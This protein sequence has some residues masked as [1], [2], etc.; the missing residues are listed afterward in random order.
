VHLRPT[1]AGPHG[2]ARCRNC[3]VRLHCAGV[4]VMI[5]GVILVAALGAVGLLAS[6]LVVAMFRVSRGQPAA[7]GGRAAGHGPDEPD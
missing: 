2:V 3:P 1:V 4:A 5:S 7:A 6:W